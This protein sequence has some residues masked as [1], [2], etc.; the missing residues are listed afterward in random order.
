MEKL[1]Y[2]LIGSAVL[3]WVVGMIVGLI[4][5]LPYG[6]VGLVALAGGGLLLVKVLKDRLTSEED[7][8]YD[9]NIQQ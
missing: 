4:V 5:V 3:L 2:A 7:N 8:Y 1:G 9:K 6:L